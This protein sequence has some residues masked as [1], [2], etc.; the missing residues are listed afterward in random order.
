M[1]TDIA[2]FARANS[3]DDRR[4]FGIR[5]ADRLAHLYAI[6]KTGTGKST[7]L[8]TLMQTDLRSGTGFAL[9]DPHGDLS[10]KVRDA[11]PPERK[12]D[13]V[14][15]NVPDASRVLGFNP[16]APAVREARPLIA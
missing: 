16:L 1:N 2:F 9:L 13:L 7:L 8:E 3:R 14:Y 5:Q 12:Q 6:G 11:V 15:F 4:L 10:E